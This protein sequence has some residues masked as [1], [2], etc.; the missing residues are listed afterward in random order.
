MFRVNGGSRQLGS[1]WE[2]KLR[3]KGLKY[4][5]GGYRTKYMQKFGK[6]RLVPFPSLFCILGPV[7]PHGTLRLAEGVQVIQVL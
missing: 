6:E 4:H 2:L 5:E 1:L 7:P 3:V